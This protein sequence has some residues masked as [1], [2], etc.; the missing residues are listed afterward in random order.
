VIQGLSSDINNIAALRIK[1]FISRMGLDAH[2]VNLVHDSILIEIREDQAEEIGP[3][4]A[5]IMCMEPYQ[6]FGVPLEVDVNVSRRWGGEMDIESLLAVQ[7]A[8]V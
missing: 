2:I 7:E 1:N 5:K 3:W 8:S 6:G 4:F